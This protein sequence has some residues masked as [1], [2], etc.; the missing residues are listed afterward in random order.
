MG[1]GGLEDVGVWGLASAMFAAI[2]GLGAAI[3]A[4]TLLRRARFIDDLEFDGGYNA[5]AAVVDR[6]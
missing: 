4:T 5:L 3:V 2:A 1:T 6:Q